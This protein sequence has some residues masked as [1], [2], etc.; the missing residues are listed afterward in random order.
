VRLLRGP[1]ASVEFGLSGL[2]AAALVEEFAFAGFKRSAEQHPKR[3][4]RYEIRKDSNVAGALN[5]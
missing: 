4:G 5:F 2:G 3:I 1:G